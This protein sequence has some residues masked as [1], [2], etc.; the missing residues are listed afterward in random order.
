MTLIIIT[1]LAYSLILTI[2][3]FVREATNTGDFNEWDVLL[4]GPIMWV[5]YL[6]ITAIRATRKK[7][8]R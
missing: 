7:V 1:I 2:S 6:A 5:F 4:Y 8:K 3:G